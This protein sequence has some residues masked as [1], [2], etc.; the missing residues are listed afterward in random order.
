VRDA[1]GNPVVG[2]TVTAVSSGLSYQRVATTDNAGRYR[3]EDVAVGRVTVQSFVAPFTLIG[4]GDLTASQIATIDLRSP[5]T[6]TVSGIVRDRSGAPV[7]GALVFIEDAL[8]L[9]ATSVLT[10]AAGA[11][12]ASWLTGPARMTALRT[13][14]LTNAGYAEATIDSN[15]RAT[16][17]ITLGNA[18][19]AFAQMV[20]P[21]ADGFVYKVACDASLAAGGTAD[22]RLASPYSTSSYAMTIDGT[23]PNCRRSLLLEQNRQQV[24]AGAA[25]AGS[26]TVTRKTFVPAGG[27]FV[28]FLDSV[29]NPTASEMTIV[30]EVAATLTSSTATHVVVAPG[31]TTPYAVTDGGAKPS[32][33]HVFGDGVALSPSDVHLANGDAHV[34]YRWR[35]TIPAGQTVSLM[36]FSAQRGAGDQAGAVD[37]ATALSALRL[38]DALTGLTAEERAAIINFRVP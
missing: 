15:V 33:A 7:A 35:V 19:Y 17:D 29:T 10:D 37:A 23:A 3:V 8:G 12:S 9:S 27:S 25:S 1:S 28:R 13:S 38:A 20:L 22:G 18:V 16:A 5:Q 26:L 2:A 4:R 30:V 34:S 36:H 21:A 24:V 6:G 32:V 11:Y 14:D 31:P